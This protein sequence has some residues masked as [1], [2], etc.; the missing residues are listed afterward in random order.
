MNTEAASDA[1]LLLALLAV[2]SIASVFIAG[3]VAERRG[4]SFTTWAWVAAAIGPLALPLI[5][6]FPNLHRNREHR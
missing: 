5:F 6:L 3:R 1:A 2:V 4:R